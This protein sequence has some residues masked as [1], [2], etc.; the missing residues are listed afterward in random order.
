MPAKS[1]AVDAYIAAAAPFAQ[2]ILK[3]VRQLFHK[4]CPQV[5]ETMKWN[6]PFFVHHGTLGGVA[7]FKQHVNIIFWRS[8]ELPDPKTHFKNARIASMAPF[9][10]ES[11]DDLPSDASLLAYIKAA[12]ALNE[13]GPAKPKQKAAKRPPPVV[14][15]D[16]QAALRRQPKAKKSFDAMSPSHQREYVEWI[17]EAKQ[18]ATRERRIATALEWLAEGKPRHW[19]YDK[20]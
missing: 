11:M 15:A 19:K 20:C 4:A 10:L 17:T 1:P 2:P 5:E 8:K 12:V 14:P 13:A 16:F 7:A 3:K 9:K 6:T 18:D